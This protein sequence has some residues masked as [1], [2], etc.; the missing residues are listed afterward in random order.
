[1]SDSAS[2]ADERGTSFCS[3]LGEVRLSPLTK[4][5][6]AQRNELNPPAGEDDGTPRPPSEQ[7]TL[8][9]LFH[10]IRSILPEEQELIQVAPRTKV[11]EALSIMKAHNVSQVPVVT[12]EEVLGN[13]GD[14]TL[15]SPLRSDLVPGRLTTGTSSALQL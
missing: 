7:R 15:N 5:C 11:R 9:D 4:H 3:S 8:S 14:T 10:S 1:M 2:A 12:G 13:S 6:V